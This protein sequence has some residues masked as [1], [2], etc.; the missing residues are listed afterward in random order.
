[1]LELEQIQEQTATLVQTEI[2]V[3]LVQMELEP[4]QVIVEMQAV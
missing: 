3:T 1:M 4:L 2:Q